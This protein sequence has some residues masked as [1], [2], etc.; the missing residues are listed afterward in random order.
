MPIRTNTDTFLI[1][2]SC[3]T[4]DPGGGGAA[5]GAVVD[6]A[7]L[8]RHMR[9]TQGPLLSTRAGLECRPELPR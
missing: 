6:R 2:P 4:R 1:T 8:S 3:S 5:C 9:D 7:G